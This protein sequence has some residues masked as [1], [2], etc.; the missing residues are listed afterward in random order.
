MMEE[1]PSGERVNFFFYD[2]ALARDACGRYA[3][4]V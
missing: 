3:V 4:Y 1:E 2:R